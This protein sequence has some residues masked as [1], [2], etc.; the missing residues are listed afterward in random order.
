MKAMVGDDVETAMTGEDVGLTVSVPAVGDIVGNI[1]VIVGLDV[2]KTETTGGAVATV[3]EIVGNTTR[4]VGLGVSA[5]GD[6]VGNGSAAVGLSVSMTPSVGDSVVTAAVGISVSTNSVGDSVVTSTL[7]L[8]VGMTVEGV[9]VGMAVEGVSVV[10]AMVVGTMVVG[11]SVAETLGSRVVGE[12]VEGA[13]VGAVVTIGAAAKNS[14]YKWIASAQN[15]LEYAYSSSVISPNSPALSYTTM[16]PLSPSQQPKS[17]F[18]KTCVPTSPYAHKHAVL[19]NN[20]G[21]S[22]G[23]SANVS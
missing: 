1:I 15:R 12:P 4:G 16:C 18:N 11:S 5:T 19:W 22:S 13:I 17:T 14:G 23:S 2:S 21:N 10:G 3:G 6:M 20:I 7:G 8:A 9:S